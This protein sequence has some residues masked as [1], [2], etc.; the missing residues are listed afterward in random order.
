MMVLCCKRVVSPGKDSEQQTNLPPE[1]LSSLGSSIKPSAASSRLSSA[2][3]SSFI[4]V[5][6]TWLHLTLSLSL[7]D[8]AIQVKLY[9][10]LVDSFEVLDHWLLRQIRVDVFEASWGPEIAHQH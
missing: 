9:A 5:I 2:A 1:P 7:G 8:Q 10:P 4:A 6:K 3:A